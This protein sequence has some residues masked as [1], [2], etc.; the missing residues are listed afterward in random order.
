MI[1][2]SCRSFGGKGVRMEQT[3]R[4]CH[5]RTDITTH[6]FG[7]PNPGTFFPRVKSEKSNAVSRQDSKQEVALTRYS[8]FQ[9]YYPEKLMK[10]P[11]R[12]RRRRH[13]SSSGHNRTCRRFRSSTHFRYVGG[14]ISLN[15][16]R[17][18]MRLPASHRGRCGDPAFSQH[19][20]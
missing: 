5:G 4:H 6:N 17:Q 3:S 12:S 1:H 11:E 18:G 9:S 16:T 2:A 14:R 13:R 7:E 8:L 10:R 15:A 20:E 19:T